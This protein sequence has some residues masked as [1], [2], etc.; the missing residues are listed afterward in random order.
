MNFLSLLVSPTLLYS[1]LAFLTTSTGTFVFKACSAQSE[2]TTL[3]KKYSDLQ[4]H[5]AQLITNQ[6]VIQGELNKQAKEIELYNNLA[7]RYHK[8]IERKYT[9]PTPSKQPCEFDFSFANSLLLKQGS[10]Q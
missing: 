3:Q 2:L 5:N 8:E 4:E 7:G 1:L 6:A 9:L 10:K